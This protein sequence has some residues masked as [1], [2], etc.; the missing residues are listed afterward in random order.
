MK[1]AQ[2]SVVTFDYTLTDSEGNILDTSEG[3]DSFAYIQGQGQIIPGLESAMEG[4]SSGDSF[5]ITIQPEN[6]YGQYNE[7]LVA[8]IP[9]D[10]FDSSL[11]IKPG[12]QFN[13]EREGQMYT[14]TVVEVENDKVIVDGNHPL[15]GYVLNFK[16]AVKGV[17]D[18]TPEELDH[19]HVHG[20]GGH[21]H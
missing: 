3:H 10:Q 2:N 17:R 1:I 8:A 11:E 16:V 14:L 5:E 7:D 20:P 9:R 4:R 12:M 13:A 6:A 15:A 21:H 18:A 19:G